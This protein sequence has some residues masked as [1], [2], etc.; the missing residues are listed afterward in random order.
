VKS[1][2]E[3]SIEPSFYSFSFMTS[4]MTELAFS[5]RF[6]DMAALAAVDSFYLSS[7][8][9]LASNFFYSS[10][11]ISDSYFSDN[12]FFSLD[13]CTLFSFSSF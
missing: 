1:K 13:S 12:S 11:F 10:T 3:A 7:S 6:V 9:F 8:A 4:S 5:V 2:A